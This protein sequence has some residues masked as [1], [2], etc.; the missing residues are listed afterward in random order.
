MNCLVLLPLFYVLALCYSFPQNLKTSSSN[1][2]LDAGFTEGRTA[3]AS[4]T[5]VNLL[6]L[7]E[8]EL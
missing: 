6:R 1:Q 4:S 7:G 2:P 3:V 5:S 8:R